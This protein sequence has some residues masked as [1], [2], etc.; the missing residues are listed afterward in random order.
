MLTAEDRFRIEAT[1]LHAPDY[2]ILGWSSVEVR[3]AFIT[4][5]V[6]CIAPSLSSLSGLHFLKLSLSAFHFLPDLFFSSRKDQKRSHTLRYVLKN[7][8]TNKVL[9]V[10]L[11][12]LYL[13]EDLDADGNVKPG[14]Q[15]GLPFDKRDKAQAG[16]NGTK[17]SDAADGE[18][19]SEK[20]NEKFYEA[21]DDID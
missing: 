7:R 12:T 13:N 20:E 21:D 4:P 3:S 6:L 15:G 8:K 1:R 19:P 10:I 2:E 16:T 11:F 5:L 14:V 17:G 18:R 9:L